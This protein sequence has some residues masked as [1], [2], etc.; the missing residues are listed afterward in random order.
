MVTRFLAVLDLFSLAKCRL[1]LARRAFSKNYRDAKTWPKVTF[2]DTALIDG[3]RLGRVAITHRP[4]LRMHKF[5]R[6]HVPEEAL[7]WV[8]LPIALEQPFFDR[9]YLNGQIT[10]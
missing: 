5:D 8:D 4:G 1:P 3:N 9:L 2:H 10:L 6:P 7:A